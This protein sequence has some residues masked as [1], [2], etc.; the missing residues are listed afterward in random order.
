MSIENITD[1]QWADR[2]DKLNDFFHEAIP[3][4]WEIGEPD[5]SL[6]FYKDSFLVEA[7]DHF[8][9]R[10][11]GKRTYSFSEFVNQDIDPWLDWEQEEMIE[12]RI[13][14]LQELIRLYEAKRV[15]LFGEQA[16]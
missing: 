6:H 13:T 11:L 3:K 8:T 16:E 1:E 10:L 5:L 12:E 7:S 4:L 2:Y 14:S 9:E 15:E